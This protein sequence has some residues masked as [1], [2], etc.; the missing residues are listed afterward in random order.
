[1]TECSGMPE[2]HC[3][4]CGIAQREH[5]H[6]HLATVC[7]PRRIANLRTKTIRMR[8]FLEALKS[9]IEIALATIDD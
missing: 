4:H 8:R 7:F 5:N 6:E 1:M 3:E 9:S 2:K